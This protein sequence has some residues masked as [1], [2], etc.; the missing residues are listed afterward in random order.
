MTLRDK[1]IE[2]SFPYKPDD[3]SIDG[4]PQPFPPLIRIVHLYG[5]VT[6]VLNNI[7]EA[8][9]VNPDTMK[10][11]AGMEKDLTGQ[12]GRIASFRVFSAKF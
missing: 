1:D 9:H 6:D 7:N 10:R 11:L 4:W 2:I 3:Q 8:N 12:W 5:R